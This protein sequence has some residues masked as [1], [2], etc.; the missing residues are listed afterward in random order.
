MDEQDI[1]DREKESCPSCPSMSMD[2][3]MLD[4]ETERREHNF[5]MFLYLGPLCG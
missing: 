4:A 1:Q 3:L 5:L 2:R